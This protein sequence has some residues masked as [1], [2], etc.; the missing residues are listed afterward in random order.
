MKYFLLAAM[1]CVANVAQA[2]D[3]MDYWDHQRRGANGDGADATDEWFNDASQQ[4]I[5]F[6][7]LQVTE[8]T[9]VG[10]DFLIGDADDWNGIPEQDMDRL[11]KVLDRAAKHD[12]QIVLSMFSVPGCRTRQ[13]NDGQ[14]DYRLWH[15]QK[16]QDQAIEFW[17]KLATELKDHPAI[18]GY[19]ILNEPAPEREHEHERPTAEFMQWRQQ[20]AGTVADLNH[21]YRNAVT[22]IRSVDS[23]TPI[24]LDCCFH[25]H[26]EGMTSMERIDAP[27]LLYSFHFYEPWNYT[28]FRINQGRFHYPD[29]MPVGWTGE[30]VRWERDEFESRMNAVTRWATEHDVPANRILVGEVG[31][32]RRVGGAH[33]YLSDTLDAIENQGW[34]WAFYSFRSGTWDGMDY[35]LGT[36]PLGEGYWESREAGQSHDSLVHRHPN[37]LWNMLSGRLKASNSKQ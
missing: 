12:V 32:N 8:M 37:P 7:R 4:G 16:Y 28:T 25:A 11:R 18:V 36:E 2:S 9:P 6:M 23:K 3:P 22:A 26:P 24:V 19:N 10:R 14:F 21:F 1:L 17:T 29:R 5:E 20:I 34:H 30:T 33:Q 31:C 27:N 15:D 13:K 35:E